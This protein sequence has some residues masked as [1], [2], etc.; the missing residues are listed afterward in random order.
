MAWRYCLAGEA[1]KAMSIYDTLVKDTIEHSD[2]NGYGVALLLAGDAEAAE[3]AFRQARYGYWKSGL[4]NL[5]V[6]ANF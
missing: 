4:V 6:G 3:E 5:H 2:W 1:R